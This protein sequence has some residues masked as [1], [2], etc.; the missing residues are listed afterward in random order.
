MR[1]LISQGQ[2]EQMCAMAATMP[3]G[4]FLEVGVYQGGSAAKLAEV[5]DRQ[6]RRLWLFDTFAGIPE[7]TPEI[8]WHRPGDFA[9]TS[10]D[11]VRV[12][13]P[14]A[15]IVVGD[16]SE[17]LPATD[18]G[19]LAFVHLDCDQYATYRACIVELSPRMVPGSVMWFDDYDCLDGATK[20]VDEL[21][22]DRLERHAC[23]KFFVRF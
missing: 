21:F 6:A 7:W 19:P 15:L 3:L 17:T 20:A 8:D 22:G 12:Q 2:L 10:V 1:S 16:A 5:A 9:D 13:I 18:T 14:T 23:D 11:A 4:D